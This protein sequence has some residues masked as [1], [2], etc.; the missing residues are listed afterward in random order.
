MCYS[1]HM[2]SEHNSGSQFSP[3]TVWIQDQLRLLGLVEVAFTRGAI[4][5]APLLFIFKT[6]FKMYFFCE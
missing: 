4:S 3:S 2:R 5:P 1:T 6:A